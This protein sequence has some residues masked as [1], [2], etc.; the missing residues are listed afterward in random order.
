MR[1]NEFNLS[2]AKGRKAAAE[3]LDARA[4]SGDFSGNRKDRVKVGCLSI[5]DDRAALTTAAKMIRRTSGGNQSSSC[6][7]DLREAVRVYGTEAAA[8]AALERQLDAIGAEMDGPARKR[9]ERALAALRAGHHVNAEGAAWNESAAILRDALGISGISRDPYGRRVNFHKFSELQIS[10]LERMGFIIRRG[11][12]GESGPY[13]I[14]RGHDYLMNDGTFQR[15][16]MGATLSP[17]CFTDGEEAFLESQKHE[18]AIV[19]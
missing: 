15:L 19:E 11:Y 13:F 7:A 16:M 6:R 17:V 4:E 8:I 9:S 2:S 3:W 12:G 10:G 18:G 1:T 14:T 5:F